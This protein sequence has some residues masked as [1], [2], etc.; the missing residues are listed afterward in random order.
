MNQ[1]EI[2]HF[3]KLAK[4]HH[5]EVINNLGPEHSELLRLLC[6]QVGQL[7]SL[8]DRNRWRET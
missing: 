2:L 8:I 5:I 4:S 7:Q 6:R 1:K 3:A